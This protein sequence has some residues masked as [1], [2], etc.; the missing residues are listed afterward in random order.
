MLKHKIWKPKKSKI[1]YEK[2]KRK[3]PVL[4]K[5]RKKKVRQDKN[6][7]QKSEPIIQENRN[8]KMEPELISMVS[9]HFKSCNYHNLN[10]FLWNK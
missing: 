6:E 10:D 1:P 2:T 5:L 8:V 7:E 4:P 3:L 9:M